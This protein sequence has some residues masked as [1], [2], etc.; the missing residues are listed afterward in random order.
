MTDI[1]SWDINNS[2][3]AKEREEYTDSKT[4]PNLKY[5]PQGKK[6]V[7]GCHWVISR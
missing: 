4:S 1:K 7:D 2:N 5:I 3:E 6:F